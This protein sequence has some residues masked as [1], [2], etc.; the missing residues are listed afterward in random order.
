MRIDCIACAQGDKTLSPTLL[1]GIEEGEVVLLQ[2]RRGWGGVGR[3]G[4]GV[5]VNTGCVGGG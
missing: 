4:G 5:S 1:K 2:V 3:T